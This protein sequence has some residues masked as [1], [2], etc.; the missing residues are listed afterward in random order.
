M[1]QIKLKNKIKSTI[2]LCISKIVGKYHKLLLKCINIA[3]IKLQYIYFYFILKSKV[4]ITTQILREN[5]FSM[6]TSRLE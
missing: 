1:S 3:Y 2:L 4:K 6:E 5:Y